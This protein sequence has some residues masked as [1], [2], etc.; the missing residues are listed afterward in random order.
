M[1]EQD[2]GGPEPRRALAL[3]FLVSLVLGLGIHLWPL[4]GDP[5]S[6]DVTFYYRLQVANES[7]EPLIPHGLAMTGARPMTALEAIRSQYAEFGRLNWLDGLLFRLTAW[8]ADGNGDIW[9]LVFL[10]FNAGAVAFFFRVARLL[11]V[12]LG[13]ALVLAAGLLLRPADAWQHAHD[14]EPK[15]VFFLMLALYLPLRFRGFWSQAGGAAAMLA[16]ALTKEPFV[17]TWPLA[18]T[19]AL[20]AERPERSLRAWLTSRALWAHAIAF[21]GFALNT[22]LFIVFVPNAHSYPMNFVARSFSFATFIRQ[23]W[24]NIEPA[25]L[26]GQVGFIVLTLVVLGLVTTLFSARARMIALGALRERSHWAVLLAALVGVVLH[27]AVYWGTK[28]LVFDGRY[29]IPA[30]YLVALGLGVFAAILARSLGTRGSLASKIG[31]IITAG[32]AIILAL[33]WVDRAFQQASICHRSRNGLEWLIRDLNT[34]LPRGTHVVVRLPNALSIEMAYI[35]QAESL[36]RE[37]SDLIYHLEV[38]DSRDFESDRGMLRWL[39]EGFNVGRPELPSD[40]DSNAPVATVFWN[41]QNNVPE[42]FQ[43]Q[44]LVEEA[45][46]WQAGSRWYR[47]HYL[48][49]PPHCTFGWK[50]GDPS[51]P[52]ASRENGASPARR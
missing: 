1:A 10:V 23:Y 24:T 36:F 9:R 27:G 37:R 52:A 42:A 43:R 25:L 3:A 45:R 33:P 19:V 4:W 46:W 30:N 2:N 47:R 12:P 22:A 18:L 34:S 39:V 49:L 32:I 15:A 20:I 35:L 26:A 31:M 40:P 5:P 48:S 14:S 13:V 41:D 28:R 7:L 44:F 29:A 11:E 21:A 8:L 38:A 16:S 51:L 50:F 17:A 6:P